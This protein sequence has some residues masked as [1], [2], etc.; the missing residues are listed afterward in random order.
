MLL[1]LNV[2]KEEA[3]KNP[4][5]ADV[6]DKIA[7]Y[8]GRGRHRITVSRLQRRY[9]M[10]NKAMDRQDIVAS[11]RKFEEA[12]AGKVA[13]DSQKRAKHID[14]EWNSLQLACATL[15]RPDPLKKP[16][17]DETPKASEVIIRKAPKPRYAMKRIEAEVSP[18]PAGTPPMKKSEPEAP[19]AMYK[20]E[21]VVIR[22]NG[23]EVE[24][25]INNISAE[26]FKKLGE[27]L[28]KI[29]EEK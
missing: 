17:D 14:W 24:V 26:S 3:A 21:V 23:V 9:Q 27:M 8:K 6:A 10:E 12:G 19:L 11:L 29:K 7:T 25:D 28:V 16:I 5:F 13:Y 20:P 1:N 15:G 18:Q 4:K 2:L 22:Q